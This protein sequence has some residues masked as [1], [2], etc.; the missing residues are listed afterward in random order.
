MK[1]FADAL[2]FP[3]VEPPANGETIE[4]APGVLWLRLPLPFRL[5]HVNVYLLEE[6]DGWTLFDTGICN[7]ASKACWEGVFS[8]LLGGKRITRV[9]ASHFHPDHIGLAGWLCERFDAP[10]LTSFSSYAGNRMRALDP[11]ASDSEQSRAFYLRHGMA[12]EAA[13]TVSTQG[14]EYLRQVSP[15]PDTYLRLL[16]GDVLEIGGRRFE[17]LTGDGHAHEQVMLYCAA[18]GLFLAADQ[19]L[20]KITPNI[21]VYASEPEGDP[22]GHYMRALRTL[23]ER[24]SDEALVLP[25][26]RRPFYGLRRR[27][28]EILEHHE[29]RCRLVIEACRETP[30]TV[31]EIL[32]TLFAGKIL[33]AHETSFALAEAMAHVNRLI[34][35]GDLV[36]DGPEDRPVCRPV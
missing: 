34:R 13:Q 28:A 24:V 7:D 22:L 29:E 9:I 8:G 36:W 5:D 3:F 6:S 31:G 1:D 25:G 33:T 14:L 21:S 10:L 18:D 11:E 30:K 26:H 32:P 16:A 17:V 19:V 4:V 35:S 12:R 2:R 23:P 20:E 27:C 15:L